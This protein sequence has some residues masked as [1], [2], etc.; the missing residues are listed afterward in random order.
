MVL[1]ASV[2]AQRVRDPPPAS[3]PL[4][5]WLYDLKFNLQDVTQEKAGITFH[6]TE[7]VCQNLQ[8]TDI[9]SA[10]QG[11]GLSVTLDGIGIQCAG[12]FAYNGYKVVSGSG[13]L[14]ATV[15]SNSASSASVVLQGSSFEKNLPWAVDAASCSA[16]LAFKLTLRGSI[17]DWIINLFS[18]PVSALI[19]RLAVRQACD[20]LKQLAAGPLTQKL[21]AFN[22]LMLPPG[23]GSGPHVAP[24]SQP[25]GS[26][27]DEG[28]AKGANALQV[29]VG[30]LA[31]AALGPLE[32]MPEGK[33]IPASWVERR[34]FQT[35]G[36]AGTVDWTQDHLLHWVSWLL[37]D[38][39]GP[40][41]LDQ[42]LR[43]ASKGLPTTIPGPAKP[44][45]TTTIQ[46]PDAGLEL[47]LEVFLVQAVIEGADGMSTFS[48]VQA[49]GPDQLRFKVGWG[50]AL[51]LGVEMKVNLEAVSLATGKPQASVLQQM[52][53]H[54]GL[55]QP[56]LDVTSAVLVLA[57]QWP[58]RHTL[59][60]FVLEPR[61]CVTSIFQSAPR[62]VSLEAEFVGLA[63]P[64]SFEAGR[65]L[66]WPP[67]T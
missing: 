8:L 61:Q 59:A 38:V 11:V 47:K 12:H 63:T 40:Q 21:A 52:K 4:A 44:V 60:Q 58:G 9:Q 29:T 43:W 24:Q 49:V 54:I 15:S 7:L 35:A 22:H 46:Q 23:F 6:V 55:Q 37:D 26:E 39:L 62:V 10:V 67:Q 5:Q 27:G 34:L 30:G 14:T 1:L 17:I 20:K 41:R 65:L 53:L 51:G 36:N 48:P 50:A 42:A 19:E 45:M 3:D 33:P 57:D 32:A 2:A 56:S 25:A 31:V 13:V 28:S 18:A 16:S 66:S 64:L